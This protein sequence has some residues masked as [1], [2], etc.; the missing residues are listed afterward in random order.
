[1]AEPILHITSRAQWQAAQAA[2]AYQ[3]DTLA[4][5]GF[6]HCSTPAQVLGPADAL[7][8]GRGDLVLLVIDPTNV[9]PEIR[10]EGLPGG[11]QFPHVYGPLNL[12]AVT[13]VV[14]FPPQPDG[15]FRLPAGLKSSN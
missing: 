14:P 10:Y 4:T 15:T 6:I 5:E 12:D 7:F 13:R 1:M 9:G 8:R 11:E 3:G 2:G